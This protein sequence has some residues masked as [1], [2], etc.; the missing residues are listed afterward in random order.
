MRGVAAGLP[1]LRL[2]QQMSAGTAGDLL[3]ATASVAG[4]AAAGAFGAVL[5]GRWIDNGVAKWALAV[6]ALTVT[7]LAVGRV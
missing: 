4:V 7:A 5:L 1:A 3:R 6:S 2:A